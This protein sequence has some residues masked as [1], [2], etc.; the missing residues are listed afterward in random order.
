MA[1][2]HHPHPTVRVP[3]MPIDVMS[4][5]HWPK[6]MGMHIVPSPSEADDIRKVISILESDLSRLEGFCIETARE[7]SIDAFTRCGHGS[8]SIR[9][10][11]RQC[12]A[13]RTN[14]G[15]K[16]SF[17]VC[18]NGQEIE[19]S[20]EHEPFDARR[21]GVP[22]STVGICLQLLEIR[23]IIHSTTLVAYLVQP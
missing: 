16:Y 18:L 19:C 5:S 21:E 7:L 14:C 12:D 11:C 15:Q 6:A 1:Q 17:I 3:D 13:Y 22:I 10:F 23:L 9:P 20:W 2:C 4:F 8:M